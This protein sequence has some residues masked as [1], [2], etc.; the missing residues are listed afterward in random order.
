VRSLQTTF[1]PPPGVTLGVLREMMNL[2]IERLAPIAKLPEAALKRVIT[3]QDKI[4][5]FAKRLRTHAKMHF[6]SFLNKVHDK[7]EAVVSFLALL[8]LVKQR[9]VKVEQG[10]LFE[11]IEIAVHDLDRLADL[12]LEF[13]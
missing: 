2:V 1:S 13:V 12:K 3:I 7:S 4:N 10:E 8:E 11:D 5:D 9:V 6:S